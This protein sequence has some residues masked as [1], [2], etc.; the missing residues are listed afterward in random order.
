MKVKKAVIT[1]AGRDQRTLPLQT[2]V[3]REGVESSVL[4]LLVGE[5]L[6]AG[7]EQVAVIVAPGDEGAYADVLAGLRKNP[8]CVGAHLCG[9]YLRKRVRRRGLLD[10]R[11]RA[12]DEN[13]ALIR[14]ANLEMRHWV[15]TF[16][17]P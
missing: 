5:V 4:G 12:D 15:E 17:V 6:S 14:A 16:A 10:E 8:G 3:D 2:V 7:V 13:V 9:A 11:E 1:A